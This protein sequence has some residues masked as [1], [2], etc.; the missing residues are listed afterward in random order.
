V[1]YKRIQWGYEGIDEG[2]LNDMIGNDDWLYT[3]MITG[4]YDTLGIVRDSGL[5]MR[6]GHVKGIATEAASFFSS[7]YY[8]RPFLPGSRPVVNVSVASGAA[9]LYV[10]GTR[11]LDNRA[12]PDHRGFLCHFS[13]LRPAGSPTKFKGEQYAAYTAIGPRS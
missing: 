7:L 11:G 13:Q 3:N 9:M 5:E 4:Y 1:V 6:V 12:I 8:S 10:L 2:K